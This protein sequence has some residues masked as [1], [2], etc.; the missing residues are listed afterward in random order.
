LQEF[1]RV[2]IYKELDSQLLHSRPKGRG[3]RKKKVTILYYLIFTS[4]FL[5]FPYIGEKLG[6]SGKFQRK[7]EKGYLGGIINKKHQL[8]ESDLTIS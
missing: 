7:K 5:N 2:L 8:T 1:K 6:K 3:F 4:F